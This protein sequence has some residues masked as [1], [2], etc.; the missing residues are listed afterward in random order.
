MSDSPHILLVDDDAAILRVL[1]L[2][3]QLAGMR[4]TCAADGQAAL[5]AALD[6]APDLVLSDYHMPAMDGLELALALTGH[7]ATA[8]TP[9]FLLTALGAALTGSS[10]MGTNIRAVLEKPFSPREVI[11]V[12]QAELKNTTSSEPDREAA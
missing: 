8:N 6:D 4:V 5:E 7:T 2:Q 12:I 10:L 11:A 3:L 1:E 9:V